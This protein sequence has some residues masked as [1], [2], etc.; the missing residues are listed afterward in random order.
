MCGLNRKCHNTN[1]RSLK[2]NEKLHFC[3]DLFLVFCLWRLGR[4]PKK[5]AG[6]FFLSLLYVKVVYNYVIKCNLTKIKC[7]SVKAMSFICKFMAVFQGSVG[8]IMIL[9][10]LVFIIGPGWVLVHEKCHYFPFLIDWHTPPSLPLTSPSLAI[11]RRLLH[12]RLHWTKHKKRKLKGL[13]FFYI[14]IS[15][16][17]QY[18]I[19]TQI[20]LSIYLFLIK[21]SQT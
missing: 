6:F 11:K 21:K 4:Q 7:C 2:T 9:P 5:R 20:L 18:F 16:M 15:N 10:V 1:K 17:T 8:K 3:H 12:V 19:A 13:I 14:I